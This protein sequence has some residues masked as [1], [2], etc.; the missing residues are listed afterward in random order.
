MYIYLVTYIIYSLTSYPTYVVPEP[1]NKLFV[2]KWKAEEFINLAEQF[3]CD[4][5]R[6]DS[7]KIE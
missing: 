6:L 2:D 7:I 4:S 5:V 3:D 1:R